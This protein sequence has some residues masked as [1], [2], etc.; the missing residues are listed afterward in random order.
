MALAFVD[1]VGDYAPNLEFGSLADLN[2]IVGRVLR[3]EEG[4]LVVD[5]QTLD[6]EFAIEHGHDDFAALDGLGPVYDQDIVLVNVDA[7]H[8]VAFDAHTEGAVGLVDQVFVQIE[9]KLDVIVRRRRKAR[10][11]GAS[12]QR[13]TDG[14][15]NGCSLGHRPNR[16][17]WI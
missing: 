12:V 14:F 16:L 1:R 4:T 8:A 9:V 17:K 10:L 6:G 15:G 3:N 13:Q 11:N 5:E 2:G 7:L